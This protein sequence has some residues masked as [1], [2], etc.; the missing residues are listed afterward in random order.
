MFLQALRQ[1]LVWD[2][3]G[4]SECRD[5][6]IEDLFT[7]QEGSD[8]DGEKKLKKKKREPSSSK[9]S[10][11]EESDSDDESSGQ[12]TPH[13]VK[14]LVCCCACFRNWILVFCSSCVDQ[15]LKL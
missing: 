14:L 11:P 7:A 2:S 9:G 8:S 13:R 4:I 5:T 6:V 1:Y 10:G 3:E 15:V 12:A